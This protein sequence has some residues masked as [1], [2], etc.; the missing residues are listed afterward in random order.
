MFPLYIVASQLK[1]FTAEGID[2]LNVSRLNTN[3]ATGLIPEVNMWWP[4]TRNP[5]SAIAIE[6]YAMNRY[7][8]MCFR[9]N[10]EISSLMIP[11]PGRIMM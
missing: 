1:T 6:L 11:N 10:V 4:Q 2:T 8:K 9:L 7:P 5:N 3:A